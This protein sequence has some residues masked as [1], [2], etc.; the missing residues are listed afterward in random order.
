MG[1]ID[2]PGNSGSVQK[3]STGHFDVGANLVDQKVKISWILFV[4]N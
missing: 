2:L 3:Q 1:L 4:D